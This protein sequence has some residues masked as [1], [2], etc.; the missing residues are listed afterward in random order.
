M[1]H[2]EELIRL[3]EGLGAKYL[4]SAPQ[5]K[6]DRVWQYAESMAFEVTSTSQETQ[7]IKRCYAELAELV[8]KP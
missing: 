6:R 3:R 7:I 2:A 1:K 4:A 8:T 5:W